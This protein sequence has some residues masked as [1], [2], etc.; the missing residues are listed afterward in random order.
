[1]IS[2]TSTESLSLFENSLMQEKFQNNV[3]NFHCNAFVF[4]CDNQYFNVLHDN[5]V[6]DDL[7][8]GE[9]CRMDP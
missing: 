8:M 7:Y 3:E 2:G 6:T 9:N 4:F 5:S 1:M